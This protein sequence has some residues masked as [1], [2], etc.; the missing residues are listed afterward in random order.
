MS[1]TRKINGSIVLRGLSTGLNT[2]PHG[3]PATP[4]LVSLRPDVREQ[5]GHAPDADWTQSAPADGTNLYVNVLGTV[6][7]GNADFWC[8]TETV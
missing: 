1:V 8:P 5:L 6:T 4:V 3:L 2:I 7:S